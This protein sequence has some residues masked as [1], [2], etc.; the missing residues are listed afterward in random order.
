MNKLFLATVCIF[1]LALSACTHLL[2]KPAPLCALKCE[3]A[4]K[5]CQKTCNSNC[6]QCTAYAKQSAGKAYTQY[7]REHYIMGQRITRNLNSYRDPLQCRKTTCNCHADY[8]VC[9]QACGGII[10]K[11]RKAPTFC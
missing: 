2:I 8:Q 11:Q 6:G 5:I 9:I 7:L 4:A 1:V 3:K 10:K